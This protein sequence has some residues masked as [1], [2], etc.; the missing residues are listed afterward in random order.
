M[1]DLGIYFMVLVVD[2]LV[3]WVHKIFLG[4]GEDRAKDFNVFSTYLILMSYVNNFLPHPQSIYI[5]IYT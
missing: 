5:Y 2:K 3:T 4:F 1:S